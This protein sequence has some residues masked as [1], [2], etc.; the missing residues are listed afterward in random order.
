MWTRKLWSLLPHL[1]LHPHPCLGS[2]ARNPIFPLCWGQAIGETPCSLGAGEE[3]AELGQLLRAVPGFF[4]D[5]EWAADLAVQPTQ[6]WYFMPF[7]LC[8]L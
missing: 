4:S 6:S 5:P 2:Q 3:G 1:P 8:L 7:A